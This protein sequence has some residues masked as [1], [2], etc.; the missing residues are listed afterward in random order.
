MPASQI[1]W[2]ESLTAPASVLSNRPAPEAACLSA[3]CLSFLTMVEFS[4][5]VAR[6]GSASAKAGLYE[7]PLGGAP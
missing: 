5:S 1:C 2:A 6:R 3:I 7:P 4:L